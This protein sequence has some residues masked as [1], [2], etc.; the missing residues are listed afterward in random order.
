M[1][2]HAE[3]Q[4]SALVD[5]ESELPPAAL[6]DALLDDDAAR[7]RWSRHHL[8]GD[9]LRDRDA[10]LDLG[11]AARI[12][13]AVGTEPALL[14][15][16]ALP[17]RVTQAPPQRRRP[18]AVAAAL[19]AIG[20]TG[21]LLALRA[22]PPTPADLPLAAAP[23]TQAP[24]LAPVAALAPGAGGA[25]PVVHWDD[26][27]TPSATAPGNSEFQRRLNSYLVNFNEQRSN[28]GVPGVHPYVRIVGFESADEP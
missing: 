13:A 15:P 18:W 14:A 19:A 4:F 27:G 1:Q 20:V 28:L 6:V 22:P 2:Q 26:T 5:D 9:V 11:L 16:A 25:A 21:L 17:P 10:P 24:S 23:T 3:E 7:R 8:I 12:S